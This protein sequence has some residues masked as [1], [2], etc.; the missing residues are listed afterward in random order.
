MLSVNTDQ[1]R[2]T[3]R[4]SIREG[5]I[6]WRCWWDGAMD[7][8]ISSRWNILSFPTVFVIDAKG[9]IRAITPRAT[10]INRMVDR[11]LDKTNEP[12]KK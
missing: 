5:E 4:K 7:G 11:L 3:L 9:V 2:E 1:E 10:E 8:P 6:T 12:R